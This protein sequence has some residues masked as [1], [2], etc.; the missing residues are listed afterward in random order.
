[1]FFINLL[2]FYSCIP[3]TG[4]DHGDV[5]LGDGIVDNDDELETEAIDQ[6]YIENSF[7]KDNDDYCDGFR[8][9]IDNWSLVFEFSPD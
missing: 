9:E 1:M 6:I 5:G 4:R 7:E 8:S 3:D 2:I